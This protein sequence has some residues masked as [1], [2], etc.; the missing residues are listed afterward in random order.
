MKINYIDYSK[1]LFIAADTN[2]GKQWADVYY[3][4]INGDARTVTLTYN[5]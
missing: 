5:P 2:W 1:D 4:D 3:Y